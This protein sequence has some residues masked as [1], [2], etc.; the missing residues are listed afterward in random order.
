MTREQ[1]HDLF[2]LLFLAGVGLVFYANARQALERR[3]VGAMPPRAQ[4]SV[5]PSVFEPAA[6]THRVSLN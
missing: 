6:F 4:R 5:D 2:N 1:A 3:R